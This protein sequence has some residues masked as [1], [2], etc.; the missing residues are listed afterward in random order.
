MAKTAFI[1]LLILVIIASVFY[2]PKVVRLYKLANLY[3]EDKISANFINIDKIFPVSERIPSSDNP[4]IFPKKDFNL[5][6]TYYFEGEEMSLEEGLSHFKTDGLIVLHKGDL[7]YENYW[8]SNTP[9]SQHIAFSVTKSFVSALVGI[10][11]HE[12][13]IDSIEDPITK[14]LTDF[15][16]TGYEGVSI[17]DI[18][19]MSSGVKWNEDYAD[20]KSDIN[21]FGRTVATGSSFR[22]FAKTLTREKEPGTFHH[23]VS[24]DTQMLG[25][26]LIE[27]T[28]M[29]LK[30]Y[31]YQ[32]LWN[33]I[34][35]QDEAFF[36]VDNDG[37]EMALGGLNATLR[38]YAKFGL[39]YANGGK[40]NDE[41]VIPSDWVDASHETDAP[42]LIPGE[43]ELSSSPWGYGLQWWV[44]GFP[45]T[46]F[47][48]SGIYNQYIYIDPIKN[49]V[50][51]KTSSNHRF[52][53]EKEYSKAAH[54]AMFRAI[55]KSID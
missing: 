45:D 31:L 34:G 40:W 37:V 9:T 44:P 7:L 11:H 17:K 38:D 1:F 23:Y 13:L 30:D 50:I 49:I 6:N 55:A 15:I 51:A 20:P 4:H 41:M 33:K 12:G 5:P 52:T 24:I 42:H 43:H 3:N 8:N 2:G 28:N 53:A 36:I 29:P 39:L 21:R 54:V 32:K 27:V 26:L 25:L 18:L 47:T 48:A 14:Y 16:G 10:A 35:M 19:Q 22:E 46:D